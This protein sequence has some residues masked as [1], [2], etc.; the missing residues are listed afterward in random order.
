MICLLLLGFVFSSTSGAAEEFSDLQLN[1]VLEKYPTGII[2][3][4]SS[5][6]PLS[7]KGCQEARAMSR[8]YR[9]FF[10]ALQ[11]PFDFDDAPFE[12]CA[13]STV[14]VSSEQLF[15]LGIMEHFPAMILFKDGK[16]LEPILHGYENPRALGKFI[17]K[18]LGERIR[19][20]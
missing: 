4:W 5:G 17:E 3:L 16:I 12:E 13:D 15:K 7:A 1:Q 10:I 2:Y 19:A 20:L 18:T 14:K 11:D 9:I 6:M 8:R